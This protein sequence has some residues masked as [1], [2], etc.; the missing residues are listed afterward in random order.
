[1]ENKCFHCNSIIE[2]S[3][4]HLDNISVT[5]D[6]GSKVNTSK[7]ICGYSCYKRLSENSMLPDNLWRHVVN[8]SD[9]KG[10]ISPI[11]ETVNVK[12]FEYLTNAEID[13]LSFKDKEAYFK[14]ESNQ[15]HFDTVLMDIRDEINE[16]DRRTAFLELIEEEDDY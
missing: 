3:W 12:E 4:L 16:E 2:K 6:T 10:L 8:K 9:Y 13:E 15:I 11:Q 5:D 1:M 14:S 7:H